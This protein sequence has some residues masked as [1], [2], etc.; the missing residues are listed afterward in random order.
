MPEFR[1]DPGEVHDFIDFLK[2][3]EP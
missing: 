2:S 3:L 1:L